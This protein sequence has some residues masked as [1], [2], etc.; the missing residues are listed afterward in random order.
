MLLDKHYVN[1]EGKSV[2]QIIDIMFKEKEIRE[3]KEREDRR[4]QAEALE[5]AKAEITEKKPAVT[6]APAPAAS[7]FNRVIQQ[8]RKSLHL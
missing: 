6:A 8:V 5:K 4:A 7:G 3:A 1:T 2:E